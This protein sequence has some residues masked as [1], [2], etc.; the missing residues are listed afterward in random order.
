[1]AKK[2][3]HAGPA[4]ARPHDAAA[5]LR[6]KRL[7]LLVL[8]MRDRFLHRVGCAAES[9]SPFVRQRLAWGL[10]TIPNQHRK[11]LL[12][13]AHWRHRA[14]AALDWTDAATLRRLYDALAEGAP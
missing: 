9:A 1:M 12:G 14:A 6:R 5:E 10:M 3:K 8:V 2:R 4:P 13:C 7:V 11:A